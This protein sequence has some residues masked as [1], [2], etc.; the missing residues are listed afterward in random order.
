VVKENDGHNRPGPRGLA[1]IRTLLANVMAELQNT[2]ERR[3]ERLIGMGENYHG[4]RV[5]DRVRVE[6]PAEVIE[7]EARDGVPG[8]IVA[9]AQ[10]AGAVWVPVDRAVLLAGGRANR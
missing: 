10:N 8:V 5:G 6:V 1:R 3:T 7:S 9:V 4:L 2:D